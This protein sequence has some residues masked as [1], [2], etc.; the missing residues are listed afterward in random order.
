MF[1]RG[2]ISNGNFIPKFKAKFLN[3]IAK[4]EGKEVTFEMKA[5]K[6]KRSIAQNRYLHGVVLKIPA[7]ELGY[8]LGEIKEEMRFMFLKQRSKLDPDS[9][10]LRSTKDLDRQEMTDFIE[11][12]KRYFSSEW[13]IYIPDADKSQELG[14]I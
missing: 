9:F 8:T 4:F 1:A 10:V 2:T 14:L 7:E 13:N 6:L 3:E 11:N 5:F 12:I